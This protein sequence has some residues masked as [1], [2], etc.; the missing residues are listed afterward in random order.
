MWCMIQQSGSEAIT[1]L[2]PE[3]Q[4]VQSM[5]NSNPRRKVWSME[6]T[7]SGDSRSTSESGLQ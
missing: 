4:H 6:D 1:N 2:E 3:V 5:L 7:D